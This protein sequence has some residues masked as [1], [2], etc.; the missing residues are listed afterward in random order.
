MPSTY[1]PILERWLFKTKGS[2]WNTLACI[3]H[4]LPTL[5]SHSTYALSTAIAGYVAVH[6]SLSVAL[7]YHAPRVMNG[8]EHN[9]RLIEGLVD[10]LQ[11]VGVVLHVT[12]G[13]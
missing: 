5:V 11:Q 4:V 3:V 6:N 13:T 7:G 10:L 12:T 2:Y 9:D 8:A 1:V